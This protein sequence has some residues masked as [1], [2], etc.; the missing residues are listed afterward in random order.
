[1]STRLARRRT[2]SGNQTRHTYKNLPRRETLL[3]NE[4]VEPDFRWNA[5]NLEHATSHGVSVAEIESVVRSAK[6]PYPEDVGNGKWKVIGRGRGDRWV[7]VLFVID[8]DRTVYVIHAR[9]I[10]KAGEKRQARRR[11]K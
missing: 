5:W 4:C 8:D 10:V 3:Y 11:S 7:Q 1:M 2:P 9:P 6:P